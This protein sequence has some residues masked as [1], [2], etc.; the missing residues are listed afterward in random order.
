MWWM[1]RKVV[2]CFIDGLYLLFTFGD[3]LI[4]QVFRALC[5]PTPILP[6]PGELEELSNDRGSC[7]HEVGILG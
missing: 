3:K 2:I 4:G 7:L 1:Q 6:L 5:R